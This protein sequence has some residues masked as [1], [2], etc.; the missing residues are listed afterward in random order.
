MKEFIRSIKNVLVGKHKKPFLTPELVQARHTHV[1]E[2]RDRIDQGNPEPQEDWD[3]IYVFSG[4]ET[5]FNKDA[6]P[7]TQAGNPYNQTRVRLETGFTIAKK[8]TALRCNKDVDHVTFADIQSHGPLLY[9][10]G[11]KEHNEELEKIIRRGQFMEEFAFPPEKLIISGSGTKHTGDQVAKFPRGVFMK[12]KKVIWVSDLYHLPR[13]ERYIGSKYDTIGIPREKLI[14][15]HAEPSK[16]TLNQ[17]RGGAKSI[18]EYTESG[19]L[20]KKYERHFT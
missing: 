6:R 1:Q 18:L 8:V 7:H 5:S 10:D 11:Y 4:P 2:L 9:F 14:L 15:Y 12:S 16:L 19:E 20:R 13:I 17:V 3:S